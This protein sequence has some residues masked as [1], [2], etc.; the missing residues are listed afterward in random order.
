[1]LLF[2][3]NTFQAVLF[4]LKTP[5]TPHT[6]TATRASAWHELYS[7]LHLLIDTGGLICF[8]LRKKQIEILCRFTQSGVHRSPFTQS[9][10]HRSPF[11][12]SG[13]HRSPFYAHR[14]LALWCAFRKTCGGAGSDSAACD[15]VLLVENC[16]HLQG[17]AVYWRWSKGNTALRNVGSYCEMRPWQ[18]PTVV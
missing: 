11:T 9:G 15:A 14:T 6:P 1:M 8:L 16:L 18:L 5:H 4:Q 17:H 12:Q 7:P 2:L 13:V 3:T 10:V